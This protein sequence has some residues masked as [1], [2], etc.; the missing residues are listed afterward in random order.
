MSIPFKDIRKPVQDEYIDHSELTWDT[1]VV[2][3]RHRKEQK[4]ELFIIGP[5]HGI[6]GDER[7]YQ[8]LAH[9]GWDYISELTD[10]KP[11]NWH[12]VVED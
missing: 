7:V 9:S 4:R 3:A 1:C 5:V 11:V 2:E 10:I 12:I 6:P 8:R